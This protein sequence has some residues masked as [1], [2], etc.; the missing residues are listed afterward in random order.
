MEIVIPRGA[1]LDVHKRRLVA[2][3]LTP[4]VTETRT[5]GTL[6]ADLLAL[7]HGLTSCGVTHVTREATGVYG[8]PVYNVLEAVEGLTV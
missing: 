1:G 5:S 3:V 7:A 2:T 6:T 4:A 8:K